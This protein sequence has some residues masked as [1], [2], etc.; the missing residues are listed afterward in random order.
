MVRHVPGMEPNYQPPSHPSPL[1]YRVV[2]IGSVVVKHGDVD[3][4]PLQPR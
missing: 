1:T 2:Q 4:A 3:I